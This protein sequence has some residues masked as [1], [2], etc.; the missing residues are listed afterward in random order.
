MK[1]I[2]YSLFAVLL[3]ACATNNTTSTNI[4]QVSVDKFPDSIFADAPQNIKID[5]ANFEF[6]PFLKD[7]KKYT[8]KLPKLPTGAPNFEVKQPKP[9]NSLVVKAVDFGF[10]QSNDDCAA[11]INKALEHCR[12]IGASKLVLAEGTYNCFGKSGVVL[13]GFEDFEID[14][15]G[16]MLIF[17]RPSKIA[18]LPQFAVVDKSA[19]FSIKNCRRTAVTNLKMDWDWQNDPLGAFVKI[20]D[21]KPA[22]DGEPPYFDVVFLGYK[23][24]PLYNKPMPVQV[25]LPMNE[26][27]DGFADGAAFYFGPSEG[28]F[29]S[30]SKWLTPNTARIYHSTKAEGLP[31]SKAYDYQFTENKRNYEHKAAKVGGIYRLMHYYY[32]KNAFHVDS[33]LHL[34]LKNIDIVSCRGM[35]VFIDGSQKY[36]Q[37]ENFNV[38]PVGYSKNRP[39]STTADVIHSA[40]SLGFCKMINCTFS[41]NQDDIINFHDRTTFAAKSADNALLITNKRAMEFFRA[42]VGDELELFGEDCAPLSFRAKIVKIDGETMYLDRSV[43]PQKGC[44][45]VVAKLSGATDNILVKGCNFV[46]FS[47]RAIFHGKN[48]TVENSRFANGYS[49]PL[50]FQM[51][52]TFDQWAEGYG[53]NNVVVRN[54]SFDSCNNRDVKY[55]GWVAEIFSGGSIDKKAKVERLSKYTAQNILIENNRFVNT[56]GL[57][58]RINAGRNLFFINNTIDESAKNIKFQSYAG[59]IFVDNAEN[60]YIINNVFRARTEKPCGV[61]ADKSSNVVAGGN[62]AELRTGK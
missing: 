18:N 43:P 9:K 29:G 47:G 50:K 34:T 39:C 36:L 19:N 49:I 61:I 17:R 3:C 41:L 59:S 20:I 2:I 33:N 52:Y 62:I 55:D 8:G 46:N 30:K 5:N 6:F 21:K 32:G 26:A 12:K 4:S 60:A 13:E 53:C 51:V 16:A 15:K 40:N 7:A 1:F 25:M 38:S 58:W 28:H 37:L 14:G 35:A 57:S 42:S 45:F 22:K 56:R 44:G 10:D 24:Y 54:C 23:N 27:L 11:A 31:M 48:V